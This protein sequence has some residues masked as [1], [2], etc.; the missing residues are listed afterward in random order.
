[1]VLADEQRSL[2]DSYDEIP[3]ESTPFAD[4]HPGHLA[5]LARLHG[6]NAVDPARCRMLELG[7]ANGGNLIPLAARL[8]GSRFLGIEL[9]AE[10]ARDG[11]AR[12]R[13][14]GL[15]NCEVRQGDLLAMRDEGERFD[16]IVAHGVWSWTPPV[17]RERILSLAA[18]LLSENGILYV[19]Y[20][21]LPGWR[22]RGMLRDMLLD[23]VR[24]V[25]AP[26]ARLAAAQQYLDFLE[27]ALTDIDATNAHYLRYE[28]ERIR[29]AHPSYLFHEYLESFNEPMLFRDFVQGAAGH[30]LD[31]VC[32]IELAMQFPA[33]LGEHV[34]RLLAPIGDPLER[35]QQ[36]DF[37][38]NRNFHQSLLCRAAARP[39]REPDLD[40]LRGFAWFADIKPP[41][42][43][44]LRRAK[45]QSF[46]MPNGDTHAVEHPLTKAALALLAEH[47]PGAVDHAEL[48]AQARNL[49]R[50]QGGASFADAETELLSELFSLYATAVVG[51]RPAAWAEQVDQDVYRVE[52]VA[53]QCAALGDGHVPAAHHRN[54]GLDAF[55]R[56]LVARLDGGLTR[57]G[58]LDAL[59]TDL[60][61]GGGLAGL[62]PPGTDAQ[63]V[64]RQA[65]RNLDRLLG[66]FRRQGV[67]AAE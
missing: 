39:R 61:E 11:A 24:D 7:C 38:V 3:Y 53:R 43:L 18:E 17:V 19:S 45:A 47:Y 36:M 54:I 32:D 35:W 66:V 9:S 58:L 55:S 2:G 63:S 8:P 14:L 44:D 30:G 23:H 28:I 13:E 31:Y 64:R 4:T 33:F 56:W 59:V 50:G 37:L 48:F 67:L 5:C 1:M 51:A 40:R 25:S 41:R 21:S 20:N 52:P 62:L 22:M 34:E 16:Y 12:V 57:E 6:V 27:A 26:A 65:E 42:K 46:T 49:V 10:Q 29:T 15:D 60:G